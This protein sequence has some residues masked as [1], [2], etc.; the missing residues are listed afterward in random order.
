[1]K[2]FVPV[3]AIVFLLVA[4]FAIAPSTLAHG[5]GH[6]NRYGSSVTVYTHLWANGETENANAAE[7]ARYE[8]SLDT[9][10][11]L[12]TTQNHTDIEV[13]DIYSDTGPVGLHTPESVDATNHGT[14][15]HVWFNEKYNHYNYDWTRAVYCQELGHAFG[16]DHSND[17]CMGFG[18]V[19]NGVTSRATG[20]LQHSID[21][22]YNKYRNSHSH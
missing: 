9:I 8:W 3:L 13:W 2:R 21:D 15:S 10:L 11:Y 18:Y 7:G 5:T 4:N 17:G 19:Y 22:I 16:L 6:W 20:V 1:M 14:H 12:P